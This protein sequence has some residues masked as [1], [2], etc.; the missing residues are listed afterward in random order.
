ML[1]DFSS[2]SDFQ[3]DMGK[4]RVLLRHVHQEI[5]FG[6]VFRGVQYEIDVDPSWVLHDCNG[7]RSYWT[8]DELE[9]KLFVELTRC[10]QIPDA[11]SNVVNSYYLFHE[12]LP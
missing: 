12:F 7:F 1:F 6:C 3:R 11:Q 10:V 8:N 5:I 2:V 9:A 4:S